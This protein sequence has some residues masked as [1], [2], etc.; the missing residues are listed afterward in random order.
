MRLAYLVTH[1]IQYQAP[2][3]R[4]IAR[5]PDIELRVFFASDL[6]LRS[7]FDPA[8]RQSIEWD[9]PLLEGYEYEFLPTLGK[10]GPISFW[11]PLNYGLVS[12]LK[13][14]DFDALWVHGY[15]RW[16]HWVAMAAA[17]RLG[18]KVLVRDEATPM[19][20]ERGTLKQGSKR[21]FFAWLGRTADCFLAI[22]SLNG[23]YYRQHG[24][25]DDCVFMMPYTVDNAF[26]QAR[27]V[28]FASRR[29]VLRNTLGLER[30][31]P[32][33]L[34]AGKLMPRKRPD[35]LL[36]AY[37]QLSADGRAEP[38]PYLLYVGDGEMRRDLEAMA[39]ATGWRSVIF[40]GFKNQTEIAAFYDL[41]DLFVMPSET[42]AWGLVVNEAMNAG[43]AVIVSDRVGCAPD[44]VR[45]GDNGF[46]FKAG[47][48]A[49]LSR[50]LGEAL[51]SP[52]QYMKMGCR[53][54][55][56]INRWSFEEDVAGLRAALAM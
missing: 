22:G 44:L 12:R 21:A 31:R 10:K 45:N 40:Q 50:V 56:L 30:G 24:L 55:A 9:V 53:S 6:S 26:F 11:Q 20:R 47:D 46:V 38:H 8:F 15:M 5:E 35:D 7:F 25:P 36:K 27:S 28:E 2:L 14:G 48:V 37:R 42:E 52:E 13:A 3:L 43:R 51:A 34:Y 18:I 39:A 17:K 33:I 1:P 4:R 41:C 23:R 54:L 49:D 29:E 16:H 19:S 32:I